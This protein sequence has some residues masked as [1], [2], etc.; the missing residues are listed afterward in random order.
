MGTDAVVVMEEGEEVLIPL[1]GDKVSPGGLFIRVS[2]SLAT[3]E[4]GYVIPDTNLHTLLLDHVGTQGA[5][6]FGFHAWS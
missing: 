5:F 4:L 6:R 2:F 1:D 3:D